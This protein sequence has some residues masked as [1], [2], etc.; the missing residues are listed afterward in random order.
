MSTATVTSKGQITIPQKIRHYLGLR[1]GDQAEFV[2]NDDGRVTISPLT[3]DA[4]E[5]KGMLP[6]PKKAVSI[7][8]MNKVIAKRGSKTD[9]R[10]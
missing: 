2:V 3:A 9:D 5:L 10:D 7:D 6:K 4:R 8:Q 1:T